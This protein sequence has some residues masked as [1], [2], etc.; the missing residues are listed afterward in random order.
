MTILGRCLKIKHKIKKLKKE[1]KKISY[2]LK[3]DT[4]VVILITND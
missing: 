1:K 3:T 2:F 4:D